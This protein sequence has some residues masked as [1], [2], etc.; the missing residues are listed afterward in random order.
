[1]INEETGTCF[2]TARLQFRPDFAYLIQNWTFFPVGFLT[3]LHRRKYFVALCVAANILFHFTWAFWKLC[4][5]R[6]VYLSCDSHLIAPESRSAL[7]RLLRKSQACESRHD[8]LSCKSPAEMS[9]V[10]I[11]IRHLG[12][13]LFTLVPFNV[14]ERLGLECNSKLRNPPHL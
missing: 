11:L 4:C 6:R 13:L 1:M 7:V 9:L 2:Y 14:L 5:L 3:A 10:F 8:L 12:V